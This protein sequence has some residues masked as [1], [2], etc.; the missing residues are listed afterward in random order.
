MKKLIPVLFVV[1]ILATGC[2]QPEP[3]V[4]QVEIG[5]FTPYVVFTETINGKVKEVVE[6]SYVG[7]E[8]D[9]KVIKGE[10]LSVDARD[11]IPWTNDFRLTYDED[12]NLIESVL[13]DENDEAFEQQNQTVV[14]GRIVKSELTRNDTLRG[15]SKLTYNEAGHLSKV[16][17]F[18]LPVDTL[19]LSVLISMDEQGNAVEWQFRNYKGDPTTKYIFTVNQEGRRTGYKFYNKEGEQTF[20][21]EFTYNEKGFLSKQHEINKEGEESVFEYEYEYG[22]L[23]NWVKVT[24]YSDKYNMVTER[25][26][27][28]FP[29]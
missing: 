12:G 21:E 7:L 14:D 17:V 4:H 26:I 8:K 10:R 3:E 19:R 22:E 28:Y 25:D 13:L 2:P 9:G 27:T 5:M 15:Y 29:E 11:S 20:E 23:D 6:R 18:R 16:E 24:G 1:A